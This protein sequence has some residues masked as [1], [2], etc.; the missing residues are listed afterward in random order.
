MNQSQKAA[1]LAAGR[2]GWSLSARAGFRRSYGPANRQLTGF[3]CK[4]RELGQDR[5]GG[6]T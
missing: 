5:K 1:Y 2:F 4:G 6:A 3:L